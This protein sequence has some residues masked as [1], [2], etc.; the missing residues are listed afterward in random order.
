MKA[1]FTVLTLAVTS[2]TVAQMPDRV[3]PTCALWQNQPSGVANDER[4]VAFQIRDVHVAAYYYDEPNYP[5]PGLPPTAANAAILLT[6]LIKRNYAAGRITDENVVVLLRGAGHDWHQSQPGWVDPPG[7]DP[8]I[9][10]GPA[11]LPDLG[12][13]TPDV[14]ALPGVSAGD[15]PE[16][17]SPFPLNFPIQL[18]DNPRI[19]ARPWRHPFLLNATTQHSPWRKWMTAFVNKIDEIYDATHDG[20]VSEA[21]VALFAD[22]WVAGAPVA[23]VNADGSVDLAD[24]DAFEAALAGGG[25]E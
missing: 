8:E 12:F 20:A 10:Q 2:V 24:I 21:D 13:F 22:G 15:F 16:P 5:Y 17:P 3:F 23:D 19:E 9:P 14:D 25:P 6:E 7:D 18:T 11:F 1:L 4:F